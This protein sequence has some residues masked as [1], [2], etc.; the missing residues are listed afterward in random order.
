M[1]KL[2]EDARRK[3]T[4]EINHATNSQVVESN[5]RNRKGK[6]IVVGKRADELQEIFATCEMDNFNLQK[7][8]KLHLNLRNPPII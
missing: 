4:K 1:P 7:F 3:N 6:G 8:R 2:N 5:L